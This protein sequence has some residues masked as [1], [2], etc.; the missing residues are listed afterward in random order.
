MSARPVKWSW[1]D[2]AEALDSELRSALFVVR[3][4]ACGDKT[5]QS[6]AWWL[7]ANFRSMFK[8]DFDLRTLAALYIETAP[9]GV[10]WS[11]WFGDDQSNGG[12]E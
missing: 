9:T 12:T 3:D 2:K 10:S 11:E 8:A 6:A 4:V 5:A 7:C 1:K